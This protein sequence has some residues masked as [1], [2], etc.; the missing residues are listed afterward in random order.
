MIVT[1]FFGMVE[2]SNATGACNQTVFVTLLAN[3]RYATPAICLHRRLRQ[4]GSTCPLLLVYEDAA[5]LP[6]TR[7]RSTFGS[8]HLH[9]LSN[10]RQRYR[11][12]DP[13]PNALTREPSNGIWNGGRRLFEGGEV[14]NTHL[15]LWLWAL[16]VARAVFLD[17]DMFLVRNVDSLLRVPVHGNSV[18]A[19]TCKSKNGDRYFNSGMLVFSPS[20]HVLRK[21]LETAR[22]TNEPWHGHVPHTSEKWPDLCSPPDNPRKAWELFPNSSNPLRDCRGKYGPGRQPGMISKA[23]ESKYTDQSIFNQVFTSHAVVPGGFNDYRYFNVNGSHI[24]HFVGEPKPWSTSFKGRGAE[25]ARHKVALLWQKACPGFHNRSRHS[26]G[27]E[28]KSNSS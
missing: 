25:P 7:L 6:M 14:G 9:K 18:A 20:L 17:I 1:H 16:P 24:V 13:R 4:L 23:C 10:L 12:Y 21:L 28:N 22:W 2:L 5:T 26:D 19:V 3:E 8:D 27:A 15:K 11:E